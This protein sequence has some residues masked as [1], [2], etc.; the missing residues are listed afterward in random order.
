MKKV[1]NGITASS[2]SKYV[3]YLFCAYCFVFGITEYF[4]DGEIWGNQSI[5]NLILVF[6][7]F[8]IIKM[9][10]TKTDKRLLLCGTVFSFLLSA[11]LVFGNH[12]YWGGRLSTLFDSVKTAAITL[13]TLWGFTVVILSAFIIV[14]NFLKKLPAETGN[15]L[16]KINRY[17]FIYGILMLLCW[18]PCYL[19]YYPGIFSYDIEF[20][21]MEILGDMAYSRFHP[22][23]HTFLWS[24]CLSAEQGTGFN[25]LVL[26]SLIQMCLFATAFTYVLYFM[27]KKNCHTWL[28]LAS[29]LFFALNP[30]IALFSFIPVKDALLTVFFVFFCVELCFFA[31]QPETHAKN[32]PANVRLILF[33]LLCCL[34]RNNV[35]YALVPTFICIFF[36]VK[37]QWKRILL[38]FGC[39]LLGYFLINGPL[40]TALGIEEGNSREMLSV[41]MQQIAYVVV[42]NE[43]SLSTEELTQINEYIPTENLSALYNPRFADPVK[44]TFIT[45]AFNE[46]PSK[47]INLWWHL[48]IKYPEDYVVSFLNLHIPYWYPDANSVD[49]FSQRAYIETTVPD[50]PLTDYVVIRDSKLPG[51]YAQ[52]EKIASY[53]RFKTLPVISNLF[54]ISLPVWI[55][56]F[57]ITVLVAGKEKKAIVPFLP[58][59]FLWCT[60]I[61]GPVSNLRYLLPIIVLYPIFAAMILK[62]SNGKS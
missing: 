21:T 47:F 12:I 36:L 41:P 31:E 42:C 38:W 2:L 56:L 53:E 25:A 20:Q 13:L 60:F 29:F 62:S 59:L 14:M 19:A 7:T 48:F 52:Y 10:L 57:G 54:S 55:L 16:T 17:P 34:L 22:P 43:A 6:L 50:I 40:Y 35:V 28:I 32:I 44:N 37:E 30:V 51:L 27:I 11:S 23:L 39:I 1:I 15:K 18:L 61:L 9:T 58:S 4:F 49:M 45:E 3:F 8:F 46:N 26:Y 24:L 33:G 5:L